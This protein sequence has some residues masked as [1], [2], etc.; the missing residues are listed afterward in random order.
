MA[1]IGVDSDWIRPEEE[2]QQMKM[3]EQMQQAMMAAAQAE[4]AA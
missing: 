2:A 4:G 3:A 1:G